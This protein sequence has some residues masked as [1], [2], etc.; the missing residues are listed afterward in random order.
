MRRPGQRGA[1]RGDRSATPQRPANSRAAAEITAA[2]SA[3]SGVLGGLLFASG[4]ASLLY[5][6]LW[7]KQLTLV[8]G[9]DVY[10]V[11]VGVSAFFAGLA[12][13]GVLVGRLADRASRP[14]RM[15]ALLEGGVGALGVAATL[16]LARTP[17]LFVHLEDRWPPLAWALVFVLVGLPAVL[18]GGTVPVAT[19]AAAPAGGVSRT[20]DVSTPPTRRA[21]WPGRSS[22]CSP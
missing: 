10:A 7:V 8:V 12:L 3:P 14:L 19:R 5:Q 15:L 11:T 13:G 20:G 18:M 17:P 4:L 1:P 6:V 9:V 2:E 16:A 21:P 22:A